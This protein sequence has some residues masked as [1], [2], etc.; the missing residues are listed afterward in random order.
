MGPAWGMHPNWGP[1]GGGNGLQHCPTTSRLQRLAAAV[2]TWANFLFFLASQREELPGARDVA[3]W[4]DL[5]DAAHRDAGPHWEGTLIGVPPIAAG[6]CHTHG[7][8]DFPALGRKRSNEP[9]PTALTYYRLPVSYHLDS[10]ML[11]PDS[12]GQSGT[13]Q[14]HDRANAHQETRNHHGAPLLT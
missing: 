13:Q 6:D 7:P 12:A 10:R 14:A 9:L 5:R 1:T 2:G 11:G 4:L 8:A 3:D